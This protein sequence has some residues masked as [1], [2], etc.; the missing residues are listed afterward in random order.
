VSA[1][2]AGLRLHQR[3]LALL[4]GLFGVQQ[5]QIVGVAVAPLTLRQIA[6]DF[7]RIGG[8]LGRLQGLGVLFE[9]GQG[10]GDILKG[11]QH[12][13]AILFRSLSIGRPG[14]AFLVQQ[15]AA[16]EQRCGGIDA[17]AQNPEPPENN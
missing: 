4:V 5:R 13:A 12:G 16:L 9:R 14:G 6:R 8:G 2:A 11:G 10:I 3:N 17:H 1:V 7:G 15:L